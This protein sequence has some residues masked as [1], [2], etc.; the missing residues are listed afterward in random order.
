MIERMAERIIL[1]FA[2]FLLSF[3]TV[4]AWEFDY[5][6]W[7]VPILQAIQ[8][9]HHETVDLI[10][11]GLSWLGTGW[12][13]W[14]LSTLTGLAVLLIGSRLRRWAFVFWGGLGLGAAAM[15]LLKVATSRPR[16][17]APLA[18]V[19]VE[20]SGYSF[21]SGHVMFFVQYFGF[22]YVLVCIFSDQVPIR[23]IALLVLSLPILLVGYSRIYLGAH[24]ASDVLGGYL[25]GGLLLLLMV[26][27]YAE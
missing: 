1:A 11:R 6:A 5:F 4:L 21:P 9:T 24:W 19:L 22:L 16:P 12:V 7:D 26:K 10:L 13:P 27:I 25:L 23:R 2:C 3:L 15:V 18:Q 14:I 20:Y 8:S 17:S